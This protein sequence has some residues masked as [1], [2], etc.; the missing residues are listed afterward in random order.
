MKLAKVLLVTTCA[1]L[2][3]LG[4]VGS[5]RHA[6][7]HDASETDE[8]TGSWTAPGADSAEQSVPTVKTRPLK[9]KGC[10]SGSVTDM[11][12]GSGTVT[13]QFYQNSNRKK[14]VVGSGAH[15]AWPDLAD[16]TVPLKGSVTPTGFTFNGN[17]GANCPFVSG[18]ATGNLT[19]LTGTVVFTGGCAAYFQN[20]SFSIKPG[21]Q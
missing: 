7:A 13:F 1:G 14:L 2:L 8:N 6:Y 5:T 11:A 16:A 10:W 15:F 18:S 19:A 17:A 9:L 12:D 3:S 4:M 21:C 20:V